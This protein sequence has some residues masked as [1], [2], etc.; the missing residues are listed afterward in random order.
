MKTFTTPI[1]K[2]DGALRNI[3]FSDI[4]SL[5]FMRNYLKDLESENSKLSGENFG[6]RVEKQHLKYVLRELMLI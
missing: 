4:E 6:L 5:E 1:R 2:K 3:N